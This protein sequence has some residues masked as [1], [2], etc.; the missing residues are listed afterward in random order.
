M[1]KTLMKK[2][3]LPVVFLSLIT[4]TAYAGEYPD[5]EKTTREFPPVC[6]TKTVF[7]DKII[8]VDKIVYVDKPV[9]QTITNTVIKEVPV[10]VESPTIVYQPTIETR[11]VTVNPTRQD[12]AMLRARYQ[13]IDAK[14][15]QLKALQALM[16]KARK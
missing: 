16:S 15:K 8:Y 9:V 5:Q 13:L 3:I 7:V 1:G 11:T 6:E 2:L 10:R 4:S 12:I 14:Y